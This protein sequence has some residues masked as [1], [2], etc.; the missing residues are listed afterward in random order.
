MFNK[1]IQ[2][3][4]YNNLTVL[5][6]LAVFI[7]STAVFAQTETGQEIIGEK[8]T[9]IQG[10][11]K[12]L[13]LE[14]DLDNFDMDYKIEKIEEDDPSTG[15]GQGYYYVTY[16]YLDLVN[17]NSAWQYQIQ[18]KIKKVSKKL[19]EDLGIYL[20]EELK[21]EYEA[22]IKDLKNIKKRI[23]LEANEERAEVTRYSG[24]IGQTL[25][26]ASKIFPSYSPVKTYK[27]PTPEIPASIQKSEKNIVEEDISDNIE[28]I[29]NNYIEENDPDMDNVFGAMDNCPDNFNP[30]Q[31]DDDE[32]GVGDVCDL[33]LDNV[34]DEVATSTEESAT[35]TEFEIIDGTEIDPESEEENLNKEDS[36]QDTNSE[37][38]EEEIVTEEAPQEEIITPEETSEEITSPPEEIVEPE[39]EIIEL[40]TEEPAQENE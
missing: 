27:I 22:R 30:D 4:K 1:I 13:L 3:I 23:S 7:F 28:E 10:T 15:S 8:E 26:I 21:E 9:S 36:E 16:T 39:V 2:F 20:A 33:D 5:I 17:H 40:P 18:E 31:L 34:I 32:D 38:A 24:L 11:D 12:T 14:A 6:L 25:D 37:I 29:Y 19:K 35:A